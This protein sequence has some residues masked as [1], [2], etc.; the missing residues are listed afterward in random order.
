MLRN[1]IDIWE[2]SDSHAS[3]YSLT[4][5]LMERDQDFTLLK[6]ILREAPSIAH[7]RPS[8][9]SPGLGFRNRCALLAGKE[10]HDLGRALL[11]LIQDIREIRPDMGLSIDCYMNDEIADEETYVELQKQGIGGLKKICVSGSFDILPDMSATWCFPFAD[12]PE[13]KIEN[14][15]EY[16]DIGA[17]VTELQERFYAFCKKSDYN[18]F[19]CTAGC[20]LKRCYQRSLEDDGSA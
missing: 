2:S 19:G 14:V 6:E 5:T 20:I 18:P 4:V 17:A 10:N 8:V 7:V 1:T 9:A 11:R 13:M 15:L 16:D 3:A 12:T